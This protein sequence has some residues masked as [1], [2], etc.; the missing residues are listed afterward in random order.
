[1]EGLKKAYA[2]DIPV[3]SGILPDAGGE[4]IAHEFDYQQDGGVVYEED[5]VK[6]TSFPAEHVI[7]GAVSYRLD[8][9]GLSFVFGGDSA[10]NKWFIENS[11]GGR[12]Q[13]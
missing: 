5:G 9:D 6:I 4:L 13:V 11:T 8:W 2:W 7:D 1:M 3:R 10:P 12:G